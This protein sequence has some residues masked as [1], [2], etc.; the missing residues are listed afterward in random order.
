MVPLLTPAGD[1]D[2]APAQEADGPA[3]EL[4]LEQLSGGRLN[5]ED[6]PGTLFCSTPG[7]RGVRLAARSYRRWK[8]SIDDIVIKA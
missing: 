1:D 3:P 8:L 4:K 5:L 7:Q 6:R 2:C